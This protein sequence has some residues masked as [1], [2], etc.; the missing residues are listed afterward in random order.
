MDVKIK[1]CG[2]KYASNINSV[3]VLQPDFMGFIFYPKSK[4]FVGLDF[5]RSDLSS[6]NP[7]INK[8][9]VFVNAYLNEVTEFSNIYGIKFVQLHGDETPEFCSDLRKNNFKVIKAFGVDEEFD[10][11]TLEAYQESVDYFLFDTKTPEHGGSGKTFNWQVLDKYQLDIPFFLSGG[12]SL[13]NIS[14]VQSIHHPQLFG[15]DLNSKFEEE[16]GVKNTELLAEAFKNIR[17]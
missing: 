10:F 15:V 16:P 3:A 13:A 7:S 5:D 14:E 11:S 9:A 6:L 8:V 12:L 2:M 4:R 17:S 1:V